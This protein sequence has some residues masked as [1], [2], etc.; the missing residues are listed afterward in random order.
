MLRLFFIPLLL[1]LVSCNDEPEPKFCAAG[2]TCC[3]KI[4]WDKEG[5][6]LTECPDSNVKEI[7]NA[8]NIIIYE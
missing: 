5:Y 7:I 3:N 4:K 8:S 6:T 2:V 1:L